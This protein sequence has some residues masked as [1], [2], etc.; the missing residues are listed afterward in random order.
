LW[1][2]SALGYLTVW[3]GKQLIDGKPFQ[4]SNTVPGLDHP[5]TYDKATGVLLLGQPA[6]FT[7]D[8]VDKFNF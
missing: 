8:N 2:P 4:A 3:T 7:A 5:I 6:V 1:D